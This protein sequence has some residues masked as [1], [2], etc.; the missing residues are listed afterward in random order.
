MITQRNKIKQTK[1]GGVERQ[2]ELPGTRHIVLHKFSLYVNHN[3]G[4]S[5]EA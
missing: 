4:T 1:T 2:K 3:H 5:D